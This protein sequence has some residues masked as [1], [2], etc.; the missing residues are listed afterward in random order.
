[1]HELA[2]D[3]K[4]VFL[5]RP[6]RF[7]KSL[8]QSTLKAYFQGKQELFKGLE[9]D[10]LEPFKEDGGWQEHVVFHFDFSSGDYVHDALNVLHGEIVRCIEPIEKW[11]GITVTDAKTPYNVR[12]ANVVKAAAEKSGKGVVILIDEY[13]KP[14][15]QRLE[16]GEKDQEVVR[17]RL[18]G[19]YSTLKPLDPYIRFAM[20]TGVTRFSQLSIFSDLNQLKDISFDKKYAAICGITQSEL[21]TN[22]KPELEQLAE[23]NSLTYEETLTKL[24]DKYDGYDFTGTG[25]KVYNPFS[26]INVLDDK[27]FKDYWFQ[28]GT[29]TMLLNEIRRTK[30]DV[31]NFDENVVRSE[32][33]IKEYRPGTK[34]IIPLFFQSGYLTIK[35]VRVRDGKFNLGFPNGE[36][37]NGFAESLAGYFFEDVDRDEASATK[38]IDD[39]YDENL[40][41]FFDRLSAFYLAIP[42]LL[43]NKEE[44][45][46][47]TI[48]YVIFSMLAA[49][50][51]IKVEEHTSIGS[52]DAVIEL[53]DKIYVFEFKLDKNATV[54]DALQQIETKGYAA[55]YEKDPSETRKI[56]KIGVVFDHKTRTIGEW[57][58]T[59]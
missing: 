24:R 58:V 34:D 25:P 40:N 23:E 9:A 45:H 17:T 48:F 29:P 13:D 53:P 15:L 49:D 39:L 36:V 3:S 27:T 59:D 20:L 37:K 28:T 21:E 22:F 16:K 33:E 43:N 8:M 52:S 5:S 10:K 6:R 14:M 19:F 2:N 12:F 47:Q 57:K 18:R 4:V 11:C 42:H 32:S 50:S 26:T 41:N 38:L 44:K 30:F 54:D 31:L 46:Y 51:S 35:S 7:G 1:M 56:Y 55:K